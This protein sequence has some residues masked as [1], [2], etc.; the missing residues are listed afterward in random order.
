MSATA[1]NSSDRRSPWLALLAVAATVLA[2]W[3]WFSTRG[4]LNRDDSSSAFFY[5]GYRYELF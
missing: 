5:V 2:G 3:F 4:P 1:T